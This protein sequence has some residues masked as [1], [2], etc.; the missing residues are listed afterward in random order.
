MSNE[1]SKM[2]SHQ[3]PHQPK[4]KEVD[5]IYKKSFFHYF[6]FQ[7]MRHF[8]SFLK[9]KVITWRHPRNVQLIVRV[10]SLCDS[11]LWLMLLPYE[12]ARSS[13]VSLLPSFLC[14]VI[15]TFKREEYLVLV[16]V[17]FRSHN[18]LERQNKTFYFFTMLRV[19]N[20]NAATTRWSIVSI[21]DEEWIIRKSYIG[22][23]LWYDEMERM[24]VMN[25]WMPCSAI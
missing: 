19:F 3:P 23:W 22:L 21:D 10:V 12:P 5:E 1:S 9:V 7:R 25:E 8:T 11:R 24:P 2:A 18:F 20:N 6:V 15:A 16:F 17:A 14:L 13:E 4:T